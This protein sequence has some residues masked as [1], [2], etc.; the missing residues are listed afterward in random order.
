[1]E[2][3]RDYEIARALSKVANAIGDN[4][5]IDGNVATQIGRVADAIENVSLSLEKI[6]QAIEE[7]NGH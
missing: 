4:G 5:Y 6:A 7:K 2:G 1:M 3:E